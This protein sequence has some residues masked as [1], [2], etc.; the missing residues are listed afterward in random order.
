[1]HQ[2]EKSFL[3]SELDSELEWALVQG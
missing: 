2:D 1:M 3:G